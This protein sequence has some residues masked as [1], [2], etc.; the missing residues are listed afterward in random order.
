MRR[1]ESYS[2]VSA[3]GLYEQLGK[4]STDMMQRGAMICR[5]TSYKSN[6]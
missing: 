5:Y 4:E 2:W 1:Q 6:M 3:D